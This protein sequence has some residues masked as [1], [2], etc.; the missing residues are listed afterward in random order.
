ME[1]LTMTL[2]QQV[3]VSKSYTDGGVKR[4]PGSVSVRILVRNLRFEGHGY[5][6]IYK[7]YL[8]TVPSK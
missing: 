1:N 7:M 4:T 5:T 6:Q 8:H 2:K 3:F